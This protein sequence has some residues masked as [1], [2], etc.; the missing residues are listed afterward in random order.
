MPHEYNSLKPAMRI[1]LITLPLAAIALSIIA[2][3]QQSQ[4]AITI[5]GLDGNKLTITLDQLRQMP[6]QSATINNPHTKSIEKYEGVL[7]TDLLAKIAAPSG[8][9]LHGDEMRDYVEVTG[10][11]GYSAV[12]ALAELDPAFQDNKVLVAITSD[13]KP[14]DDKQG[15]IRVV[16]PQDK[17]PAR[18]VR[19]VA[20]I[21]V[22]RAP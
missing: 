5:A 20:T 17:R 7:L 18:S 14:L 1:R 4:N 6:Q 11:D 16:A 12:F 15:P 3:A 8:D 10:R 19:M 9:R 2:V 22:R 13:S 21:T